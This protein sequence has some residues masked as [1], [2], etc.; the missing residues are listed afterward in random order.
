MHGTRTVEIKI[1]LEE[2]FQELLIA[3]LSELD[4]E[5]F[6]QG[7]EY[8]LAYIPLARW[9]DVARG[10]IERWLHVNGIHSALEERVHEPQN[11]NRQWEET[12][13]AV[14][15]GRF[16][17]KPTWAD[18]P[19]DADEYLLLEIDPKMSFGTGYHESTR[20]VLRLIPERV[21][22]G[23]RVLDAGTGTGILAIAAARLGAAHVDAFDFDPWSYTNA[24]ENT[25]LNEVAERVHV[26]QGTL[27]EAP[28]GPFDLV[29]ANINR[30]ALLDMLPELTR[31]MAPDGRMVLAGL[32]K[33]DRDRMILAASASNLAP[34][35][36]ET[37]GD[38]W[39]VIL[40]NNQ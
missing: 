35:R 36:E 6:V 24:I 7:D 13:R 17:I 1:Y 23:D 28:Q 38:W 25:Y 3:E 27:D 31:R 15:V 33:S 26:M 34:E 40:R 19:P 5:S 2:V 39:S 10:T 4:F 8:L 12:V 11:W 16:L 32:L 21:K 37:E 18:L 9:N 22:P 20:L 29:L 14:R 30:N